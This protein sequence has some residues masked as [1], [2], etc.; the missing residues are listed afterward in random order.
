MNFIFVGSAA[1]AVRGLA[2]PYIA[3][4]LPQTIGGGAG[5]ALVKDKKW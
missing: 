1:V 5:G 2:V 4:L 3:F